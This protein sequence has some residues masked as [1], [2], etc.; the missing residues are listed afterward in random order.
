M[1]EN[2]KIISKCD[3][4]RLSI[5]SLNPKYIQFI[6]IW[7]TKEVANLRILQAGTDKCFFIDCDYQIF[8]SFILCN[9]FITHHKCLKIAKNISIISLKCCLTAFPK[10]HRCPIYNNVKWSRADCDQY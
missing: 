2:S 10:S 3:V 1:S 7:D 6:I 5:N 8:T 9:S 4:S